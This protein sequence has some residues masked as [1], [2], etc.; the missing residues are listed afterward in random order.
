MPI[1]PAAPAFPS[2]KR[3]PVPQL[4]IAPRVTR[5]HGENF[6]A[7]WCAEGEHGWEAFSNTGLMEWPED[8]PNQPIDEPFDPRD[9]RYEK[10]EDEILERTFAAVRTAVAEAFTKVAREVLARERKRQVR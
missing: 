2:S 5:K 7:E 9:A 8:D 4:K 6:A 10:I 1:K 3:E